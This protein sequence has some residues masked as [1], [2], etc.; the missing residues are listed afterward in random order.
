[1]YKIKFLSYKMNKHLELKLDYSWNSEFIYRQQ[2]IISRKAINIRL[3]F[4][5]NV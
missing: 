2:N 5:W 4:I 3:Q 1:M